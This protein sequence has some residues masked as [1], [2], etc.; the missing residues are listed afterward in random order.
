[1]RQLFPILLVLWMS[2]PGFSQN[3][4]ELRQKMVRE[5]IEN[6]GIHHRATLKAMRKVE[7]H[8]FVPPKFQQHAYDDSPLLIGYN[9]TIS[10]PYIVGYM[11]QML[12]PKEGDRI[13]EVGT[14]SGYQAAVLAEIVDK[15]YTIE[16]VKE[17]G[18]KAK[19]LLHQLGYNNVEVIIGDGYQGLASQAPFDGIIVTAAAE[20]IPPPLIRQLKEGGRMVIPVGSPSSVQ[21]LMLITKR[22][23]K[24]F[25]REMSPVRFVPFTRDKD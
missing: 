24:I 14:G 8:L 5:Q 1:M 16:I 13:L 9:Q 22:N 19:K 2:K 15:V 23:G 20:Q 7:R 17:L 6:R 25:Q 4:E 21:T 11:T 3:Y 18:D 12:Q 10:Q